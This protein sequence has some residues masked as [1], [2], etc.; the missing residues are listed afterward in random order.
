MMMRVFGLT[1]WALT[2]AGIAGAFCAF[3]WE[4]GERGNWGQLGVSAVVV[5]VAMTGELIAI[6]DLVEWQGV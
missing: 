6:A 2:F 4:A 5:L 1:F 3:G